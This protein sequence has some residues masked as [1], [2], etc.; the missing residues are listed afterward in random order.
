[1]SLEDYKEKN[2]VTPFDLINPKSPRSS[3]DLKKERMSICNDCPE[4]IKLTTQCKQCH[5]I[6][7]LKTTLE[8]A[9]CPLGKW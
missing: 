3:E 4:L 1:M 5:C 9:K 6:M 8:E 2:G 7:Y